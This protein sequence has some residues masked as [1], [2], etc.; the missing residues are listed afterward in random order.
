MLIAK[1]LVVLSLATLAGVG[2]SGSLQA[3]QPNA[4]GADLQSALQARLSQLQSE[5]GAPGVTAG[6]V[7]A[8]GTTFGLAAGMADTILG[9][10]MTPQSRLMQGSVGKTYV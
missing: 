5:S 4:T 3:Q 2:L 7:L 9:I 8:D 1:R 10:A 6:V